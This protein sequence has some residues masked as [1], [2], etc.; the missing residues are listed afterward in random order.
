MKNVIVCLILLSSSFLQ[1]QHITD[2]EQVFTYDPSFW[3]KELRL[4]NFQYRR[5]C[6]INFEFYN[7]LI[8]AFRS[9]KDD[10]VAFRSVF[11]QYWTNRNTQLI[12][13]MNERQR[14]KWKR[15]I[16]NQPRLDNNQA[17]L[18]MEHVDLFTSMDP[19]PSL[20]KA[21]GW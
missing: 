18:K 3:K 9:M 11:S 14:K 6:E 8:V 4:D 10:R 16:S 17:Y 2:K 15:I 5:M 20:L 19:S 7:N 12:Q 21:I 13:T 1:A